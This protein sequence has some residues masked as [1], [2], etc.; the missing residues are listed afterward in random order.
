MTLW[1]T[2]KEREIWPYAWPSGRS[3]PWKTTLLLLTCHWRL[4][5]LLQLPSE[6]RNPAADEGRQRCLDRHIQLMQYKGNSTLITLMLN[7]GQV[8]YLH[9]EDMPTN[10]LLKAQWG[11]GWPHYPLI[12]CWENYQGGSSHGIEC[13]CCA[14]EI[15]PRPMQA[16]A[17][18][19]LSLDQNLLIQM[20][21]TEPEAILKWGI[22]NK[23]NTTEM[24]LTFLA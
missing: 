23:E 6:L 22:W 17:Q 8:E 13:S 14:M 24:E 2:R 21:S 18:K 3:E 7:Y 1:A 15:L 16:Q 19:T 4:R 20:S 9:F 5:P 10:R 12:A 11:V